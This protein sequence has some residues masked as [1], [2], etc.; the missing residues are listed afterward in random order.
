MQT[1]ARRL[2]VPTQNFASQNFSSFQIGLPAIFLPLFCQRVPPPPKNIESQKKK[3]AA[4]WL[5]PIYIDDDCHI[6][7]LAM[8]PSKE[9][10]AAGSKDIVTIS[11]E[12]VI[13]NNHAATKFSAGA[14][15]T[16]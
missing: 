13:N 9:V 2:H 7:Q 12:Q 16:V 4:A 1:G 6:T 14:M 3:S 10:A 11:H 15:L 5:V 8:A